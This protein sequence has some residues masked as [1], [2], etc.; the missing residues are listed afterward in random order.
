MPTIGAA[1]VAKMK[2]DG[3]ER[4]IW[5]D[6]LAGFG[7]RIR[8]SGSAMFVCQYKIGGRTRR[9]T[10]G[11]SAV[12]K[13]EEA[14]RQA[15]AILGDV[16]RGMDPAE[17]RDAHKADITIAELC[18]LYLKE[19]AAGLKASSKEAVIRAFDCHVKPLLGRRKLAGLTVGDVDRMQ[20][21][22]A[23]GKTAID[24]K[25]GKARGRRIVKGGKGA[26]SRAVAYFRMALAF[27]VRRGLRQDNP[28]SGLKLFATDHRERFL[29]PAE[30]ARLGEA[31]TA[32]EQ[33]GEHPRFIAAIRLL[34]LT[35]ARKQEI[36]RLRWS[37]VDIEGARLRLDDSKTG[38]KVISLGAPA[39]AI[40]AGLMPDKDDEDE[41][42]AELPEFVL[43]ALR[44]K[45]PLVGLQSA[46]ERIRAKAK[47]DDVRVHDL[48]HAFASVAVAAGESLYLTG[49]LLGHSRPETSARYAHLGDDPLK[50]AADRVSQRVAAALAG[51]KKKGEVVELAGK[52]G[53]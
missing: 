36:L 28:A 27:A 20:G 24:E 37:E 35:G 23:A 31:L 46:W 16:A 3:T 34:L 44:G 5:D 1:L 42:S 25:S 11:R 21:D 14:R 45:G 40:L 43:P 2:P 39:L 22:I 47:L 26:A 18:D 49:K 15:K 4:F 8:A 10:L 53:A 41:E 7:L 12:V 19:G 9:I 33:E 52:R 32:A 17:V 29:S 6:E 13:P 38:R 50:A 51:P 30:L 48:R